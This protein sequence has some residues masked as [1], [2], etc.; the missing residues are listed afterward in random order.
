MGMIFHSLLTPRR[1]RSRR[2]EPP[3]SPP[4]PAARHDELHLRSLRA[5][6]AHEHTADAL[7]VLLLRPQ[8]PMA[9]PAAVSQRREAG[10]MTR[11]PHYAAGTARL[12][13]ALV[14]VIVII[15]A[16]AV[17]ALALAIGGLL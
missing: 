12:A 8:R 16:A 14:I 4:R 3:G 11:P 1:K 2:H 6:L 5:A 15:A 17:M 9:R 10:T 7:P 13:A